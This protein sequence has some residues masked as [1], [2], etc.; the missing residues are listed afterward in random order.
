MN[1]VSVLVAVYNAAPY[2]AECLDSLANQTYRDIQIICINDAS[3]DSSLDIL[4]EYSAHDNRFTIVELT[5]NRGQAHARNIGLRVAE[6]KYICMLDADDWF[7]SDAI[8]QAVK[9]F[10]SHSE[11][12]AV[13]FDVIKEYDGHSERYHMPDFTVLTGKE[14]FRMSLDWSIHGLYMVRSEIHKQYPYDETCRLYSDDNTTRLH[15]LAAREVRRCNGKYHYRQHGQ[16]ATHKVSI[17]RFDYMKANS[18]MKLQMETMGVDA[19]TMAQYESQRWLN[20]VDTYMFYHCHG[21]RL[22]KEERKYGLREMKKT[23][24]AINRKALPNILKSKFGY[25]PTV[26]WWMFRIE[27]WAYFTIRGLLGKN[28]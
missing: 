7:S 21:H 19:G 3:T 15:Y 6:G 11:T 5:E 23:W 24:H 18:S 22:Q 20:L 28:V 2:L 4:N 1:K 14:A 10:E 13:L 8:E 27:E 17:R 26:A 16:S 9:V 12:D 25:C